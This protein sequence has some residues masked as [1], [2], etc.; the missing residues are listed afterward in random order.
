MHWFVSAVVEW[1]VTNKQS[2]NSCD[3]KMILYGL[4]W[5]LYMILLPEGYWIL[6]DYKCSDF[7][8]YSIS[9]K[10][11]KK[12]WLLFENVS[13]IVGIYSTNYFLSAFRIWM[14]NSSLNFN[15]NF[16]GF[17]VL[18][19]LPNSMECGQSKMFGRG[20]RSEPLMNFR[21]FLFNKK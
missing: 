1:F 7:E 20:E 14:K 21:F 11:K 13:I 3:V 18:L 5:I 15:L 12:A 2:I 17:V 10:R 19:I 8:C 16:Y 6:W 9:N 4:D